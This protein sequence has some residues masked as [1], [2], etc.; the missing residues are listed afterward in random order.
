MVLIYMLKQLTFH[1]K[2][3]RV[4]NDWGVVPQQGDALRSTTIELTYEKKQESYDAVDSRVFFN[5]PIVRFWTSTLFLV[6][7][8]ILQAYLMK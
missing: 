6:A 5:I 4:G 2:K 8:L 3:G 7:F 1:L